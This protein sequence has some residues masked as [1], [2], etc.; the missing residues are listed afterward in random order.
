MPWMVSSEGPALTF[1][2]PPVATSRAAAFRPVAIPAGAAW[3]PPCGITPARVAW[4]PAGAA[5]TPPCGITSARVAWTPAGAAWTLACGIT[6]A[7]T[8]WT[9][10][11]AA[12]SITP[13]CAAWTP[14]CSI[15][16]A[17]ADVTPAASHR[18]RRTL[19]RAHSFRRTVGFKLVTKT[20]VTA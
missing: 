2:R 1:R 16:P 7:R 8:A 3:T 10:A 6:P 18:V 15:T 19:I 14:A 11:R 4:T 20:Q 12:V 9:P 17:R 5:W 13:A